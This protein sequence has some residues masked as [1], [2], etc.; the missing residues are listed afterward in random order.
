MQRRKDKVKDKPAP[1]PYR[2]YLD[3]ESTDEEEDSK[4][5]EKNIKGP[6]LAR[7]LF[8]LLIMIFFFYV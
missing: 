7:H 6:K 1:E 5:Y 3:A 8:P 4:I 2:E